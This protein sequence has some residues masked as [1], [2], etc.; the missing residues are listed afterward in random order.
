VSK[1]PAGPTDE[2]LDPDVR[3]ALGPLVAGRFA[4]NLALRFVYPFL[5]AIARG[6]GISLET[7]GVAVSIR[8]FAGI[9]GPRVG[10]AADRGRS[11]SIMLASLTLV[12]I[13][14]ALGGLS[15]GVV[16]F[17]ITMGVLALAQMAF[18]ISSATWLSERVGYARRGT[19]FGLTEL[20]W[21]GAF[22]VGVPVL[23]LLI[24]RFGWRAP[25]FVVG[26][27]AAVLTVAVGRTVPA[28]EPDAPGTVRPGGRR[29]PGALGVYVMIGLISVAV[30]L[31]IVV[32]GAWFE[33]AFGFSVAVV[34]LATI[35]VGISELLG[36]GA[37]VVLTDRWGKRRSILVGLAVMAPAAALL[38]TVG[39]RVG[40]G[41]FLLAVTLVGFEFAFVSSLPLVAELDTGARG[42]SLGKGAAVATVARAVGSALG[43]VTYTRSGIGLTGALTAGIAL[44]AALVILL[45][46]TE[47]EF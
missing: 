9:L 30:Q 18:M 22:L 6:L 27:L 40:L 33:D 12:A 14:T 5:P 8:E 28:D 11:R 10:R 7:A 37:T 47:P 26:A 46:T 13:S 3:R 23:G 39:D 17:T 43:A 38:G 34:G 19:I 29:H 45:G 24:E 20:S 4:S 42:A 41:L 36:S 35:V 2:V 16:V 1:T 25:F 21:A 31:V 32:Y 15:T 44:V